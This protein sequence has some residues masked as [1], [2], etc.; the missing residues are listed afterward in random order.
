V[1]GLDLATGAIIAKGILELATAIPGLADDI[2]ALFEQ[3]HPELLPPPP[4]AKDA[5]IRAEDEKQIAIRFDR[6]GP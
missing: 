3:K 6:A 5:E 1:S 4:P 2:R